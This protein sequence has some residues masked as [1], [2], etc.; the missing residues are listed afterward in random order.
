MASRC[1]AEPRRPAG[2]LPPA[3]PR[4]PAPRVGGQQQ[5]AVQVRPVDEA[6]ELAGR[7]DAE[8][9]LQ[10]AP[11]H[12]PQP[13]GAGGAR[14]LDGGEQPAALS[15]L[16]VHPVRPV[17]A[18]VEVVGVAALL[19]QDHRHGGGHLHRRAARVPGGQRLLEQTH[20]AGGEHRQQGQRLV[21]VPAA[22]GVHRQRP[23]R[24]RPHRPQPVGVQ[25]VPGAQ[26][27]LGHGAPWEPRGA[28]GRLL[29]RAEGDGARGPQPPARQPEQPVHGEPGA[30]T[31]QVVERGVQAGSHRAGGSM[32]SQP[33]V[34][35]RQVGRIGPE[36]VGGGQ[37]AELSADPLGV[38]AEI[39]GRPGLAVPDQAAL[40]DAD[41]HG[42][43]LA[44]ARPRDHERLGEL[45]RAGRPGDP[46]ALVAGHGLAM[47]RRDPATWRASS[48]SR[49]GRVGGGCGG[50]VRLALSAAGSSRTMVLS[51]NPRLPERSTCRTWMVRRMPSRRAASSAALKN[52]SMA[53]RRC[54]T[55]LSGAMTST[56]GV[57]GAV[58]GRRMEPGGRQPGR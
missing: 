2:S 27:Q 10:V 57:V 30:P 42:G 13:A 47:D 54:T 31:P 50:A 43:D 23:G 19:V 24:G 48:R 55:S 36:Q 46:D 20:P 26:L 11:D 3:A 18:P 22:V 15:Q 37:L 6:A 41:E 7:G 40:T 38:L 29:R 1:H 39:A 33:G 35:P 4:R 28:A 14:Q 49:S 5:V 44:D 58:A 56:G 53:C 51:T 52:A 17:R 32:G 8:T 25:P 16:D 34:D 21:Q 9:A 45:E 12:D